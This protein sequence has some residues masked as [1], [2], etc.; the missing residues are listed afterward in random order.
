MK[1]RVLDPH[2]S[3]RWAFKVSQSL[4][5]E[6]YSFSQDFIGTLLKNIQSFFD[7]IMLH[8]REIESNNQT[9]SGTTKLPH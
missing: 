9:P 8:K 5:S 4:T 6:D 1:A 3:Q 2:Q 7:L